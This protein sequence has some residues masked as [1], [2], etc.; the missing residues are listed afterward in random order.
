VG[1]FWDRIERKW[2]PRPRWKKRSSEKR[3]VDRRKELLHDLISEIEDGP[4]L[5]PD[6]FEG[7]D[8]EYFDRTQPNDRAAKLYAALLARTLIGTDESLMRAYG[9]QI[10]KLTGSSEKVAK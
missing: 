4:L 6:Q 1:Y 7:D 2:A 10:A 9:E 8:A 3:R 5:P